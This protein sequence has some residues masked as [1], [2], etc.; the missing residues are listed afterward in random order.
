MVE[1][2]KKTELEAD[3]ATIGLPRLK[4]GIDWDNVKIAC[5]KASQHN[6]LPD[7]FNMA[8]KAAISLSAI[9]GGK[10]MPGCEPEFDEDDEEICSDQ[11]TQWPPNPRTED[12][13]SLFRSF[14]HAVK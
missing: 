12:I 14:G 9:V 11:E 6:S 3:G 1:V 5:A 2:Y 4:P 7:P 8:V 13:Q 10:I